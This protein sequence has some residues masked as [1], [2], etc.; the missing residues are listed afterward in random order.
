MTKEIKITAGLSS[1]AK[2][3][4]CGFEERT[5]VAC[6]AQ[7]QNSEG[8]GELTTE[9]IYTTNKGDK[10]RVTGDMLWQSMAVRKF[11]FCLRKKKKRLIKN[12]F[13]F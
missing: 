9:T 13:V 8:I 1:E 2:S 5:L 3:T 7:G 12:F 11:N 10:W 6:T 4:I